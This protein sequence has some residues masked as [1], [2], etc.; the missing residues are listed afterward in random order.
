MKA[1][2][3]PRTFRVLGTTSTGSSSVLVSSGLDDVSTIARPRD[4]T[5][6]G[7]AMSTRTGCGSAAPL[8]TLTK[9]VPF[10]RSRVTLWK[11]CEP[12]EVVRVAGSTT[13]P[14]WRPNI[15]CT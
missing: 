5:E 9:M 4:E 3:N 1:L 13:S 6:R 11:T 15:L 12:P 2:P 10:Q 14:V 8:T 7:P